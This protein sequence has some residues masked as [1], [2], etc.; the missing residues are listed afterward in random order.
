MG[1]PVYKS[2]MRVDENLLDAA[3]AEWKVF[4]TRINAHAPKGF[5]KF[6]GRRPGKELGDNEF[7]D[8]HFQFVLLAALTGQREALVSLFRG[9][10]LV[11]EAVKPARSTKMESRRAVNRWCAA[12][13]GL[14]G[15]AEVFNV[16]AGPEPRPEDRIPRASFYQDPERSWADLEFDEAGMVDGATPPSGSDFVAFLRMDLDR[17]TWLVVAEATP[18]MNDCGWTPEWMAREIDWSARNIR[19]Q[20]GLPPE[21]PV[22]LEDPRVE[23]P[24]EFTGFVA[25]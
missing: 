11:E 17:L 1:A 3:R 12:R 14:A 20:L 9:D 16:P 2:N 24:P 22:P 8:A 25:G 13:V 19:A 21:Q 4:A 5:R 23:L 18:W 10:V 6:L 7:S 15:W